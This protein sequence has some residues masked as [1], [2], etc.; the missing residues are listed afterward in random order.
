MA[1]KKPTQPAVDTEALQG[2]SGAA[3]VDTRSFT[4]EMFYGAFADQPTT[5]TGGPPQTAVDAVAAVEKKTGSAAQQ[6]IAA[7]LEAA[8]IDIQNPLTQQWLTLM[9][10]TPNQVLAMLSG[11]GGDLG[12]QSFI[13]QYPDATLVKSTPYTDALAQNAFTTDLAPQQLGE[14][15]QKAAMGG[16]PP[17]QFPTTAET[18]DY[19]YSESTGAIRYKNG[20]IVTSDNGIIYDPTANAAGSPQYLRE[21]A[22]WDEVKLQEWKNKLVTYGYLSKEDAKKPGFTVEMRGGLESYWRAYYVNGGKP[23]QSAAGAGGGATK[24]PL[25]DYKDFSNQIQN[26]TRDQLR[27]VLGVEPTEAQVRAQAQYIMRTAT[28]LQTKFRGKDYSSPGSMALTEA[29]EG[30]ISN[31]ETSPYAQDVRENTALRDALAN[32]A[33]VSRSLMT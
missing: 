26:D 21:A 1:P 22:A 23:L 28:D 13:Q 25:V 19:E 20:T 32:A 11:P 31:I 15:Q 12:L 18:G 17:S 7:I 14:M 24:A 2:L 30:A 10:D 9:G 3:T 8:N 16:I 29:T 4:D 27:R 5:P 6:R 33:S